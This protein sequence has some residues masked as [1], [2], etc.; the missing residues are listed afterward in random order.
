MH[1]DILRKIMDETRDMLRALPAV[2]VKYDRVG[3]YA[4]AGETLAMLAREVGDISTDDERTGPGVEPVGAP[5][6]AGAAPYGGEATEAPEEPTIRTLLI[7]EGRHRAAIGLGEPVVCQRWLCVPGARA[8]ALCPE[9]DH[10][11]FFGGMTDMPE[12]RKTLERLV[13]SGDGAI[14]AGE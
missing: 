10:V 1:G 4:R 11:I 7:P 12:M 14:G 3:R 6:D 2:P 9:L 5:P 13:G 8:F